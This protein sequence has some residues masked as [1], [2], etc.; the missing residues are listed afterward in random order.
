MFQ[1]DLGKRNPTLP[2]TYERFVG[3]ETKWTPVEIYERGLPGD[4]KVRETVLV[5]GGCLWLLERDPT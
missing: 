2:E 1:I 4:W 3:K 5:Y